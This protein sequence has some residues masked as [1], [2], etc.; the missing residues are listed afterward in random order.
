MKTG[1]VAAICLILTLAN[2]ASFA[3]ET[4]QCPD[5]ADV[6]LSSATSEE[7]DTNGGKSP[8]IKLKFYQEF[9]L[10]DF[11]VSALKGKKIESAALRV[12]FEGGVRF[13]GA[14]GTDLRWFTLSTVS[15]PWVEGLGANYTKD[16]Q[17]HGATFNEASYKTR[18]W[19]VPG[20][21]A[22][23][24][25]LGNGKTLRSDV[26]A[27]NPQD[28]W[29]TI[30][31]DKRLVQALVA[32]SSHGLLLMDGSTGPD[33]NSFIHSR[34]GK[35]A[36]QLVVTVAG[37]PDGDRQPISKQPVSLGRLPAGG[38][39]PRPPSNITI[40]P[41]APEASLTEGAALVSLTVP[42]GAFAYLIKVEGKELPRWQIPFA[43]KAA[44]SQAFLL[45]HLPPDAEFKLE[46]AAVDTEG[47]VSTFA[48]ASGKSS[49]KITVPLLA[50]ADG[51]RQPISKQ[52]EIG[53]SPRPQDKLKVWAYPEICK[54]DP[55]SGKVILEK[56]LEN[57][58]SRNSVWDAATATIRITAARGEI[59]GF[60]LAL[61]AGDGGDRQPISKQPEIGVS[62]RLD[63]KVSVGGLNGIATRAWRTW[64]VKIKD[65]WQ[66]DY[67][68]P[69]KETLS[70]PAADNKIDAQ[71]AASVA[72]DLIIPADAKAGEQNGTVNV[73]TGGAEVQ[74]KLRLKVC[75]TV[76][77]P[78]IHFNPELNAYG[79]PGEAGSALW[80][81]SHRL[82]HYHRCLIN[83][84]NHSHNGRTHEDLAPLAGPDGHVT[85]W[86]RYDKNVGP[87]LDGSAF[88][89]NPRSGVPVAVLYLPQNESWPLPMLGNYDPGAPLEGANWKPLHDIQA[90]PPAQAFNQAYQNAFVTSM[91]DFVKH[92]EEKGWT[93]TMLEAFHN[94]KYQYNKDKMRGTAW[95]M[96]EPATYLDWQAL[97]FYSR[98]DHKA[99]AT[100][101]TT[102]FVFRGD[103]SRPMWQGS[104]FDGFMEMLV[105][106]GDLFSMP[107]LIK[108]M[109]RRNQMTVYVYGAANSQDRANHETAAWCLKGYVHECDGALPWQSLG[110]DEAFD[111]GDKPGNGNALIVEGSRRFGVNAI[112][113]FRVHAFRV[114]AQLAELLRL[115]EQKKGWGRAHSGALVSQFIPLGAEFRQAF[116]DDAAAVKFGELNGDKFVQLKE[117]IL[118]LLE[119]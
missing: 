99:F 103:I 118:K 6:W 26:D 45:E 94:N 46:I 68:I 18:P 114:G 56:G 22:W 20:S 106:G 69:L 75:G 44:S 58:A 101:K 14:R 37:K 72:V 33:R 19:T 78:D 97:L 7:R 91:S 52:P 27:G 119:E 79:G 12:A 31:V 66:A 115:L 35:K 9:G 30:P 50:K 100:A 73:S 28:G 85:D 49:P 80:F 70:I 111:Q 67:A 42:E 11:D 3:A 57:A 109:K 25:I 90:K 32:G 41:S 113:S 36:P 54:L 4:I 83:R 10:L 48:S 2:L 24:V 53:V 117:A 98:L 16:E 112:A 8:R 1:T 51:D 74:L 23:D 5:K 105:A 110:G 63:V 104:C 108:D 29:F 96:D 92:A 95:T 62:P 102:H 47:N 38:V 86:T 87:L 82:A 43:Q 88:K 15:S 21:K 71:K 116:A 13:G 89:D 17:G 107:A 84:V 76:I 59:A 81:D 39:S 77:P 64:F 65:T 61:V 55:L 60:Q 93:R 40:K 34:E